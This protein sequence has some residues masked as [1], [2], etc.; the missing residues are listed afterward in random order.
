MHFT[1]SRIGLGLLLGRPDVGLPFKRLY[2]HIYVTVALSLG[3]TQILNFVALFLSKCMVFMR[4]NYKTVRYRY[5]WH[6]FTPT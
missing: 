1:F 4:V 6:R 5:E 2:I 3:T